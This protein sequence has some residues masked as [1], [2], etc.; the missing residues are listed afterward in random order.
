MSRDTTVIC[1]KCQ[2]EI[3]GP[4]GAQIKLPNPTRYDVTDGVQKT[5]F[6][7]DLCFDCVGLFIEWLKE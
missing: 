1:D 4:V 3:Y 5:T 2:C 6:D 7:C